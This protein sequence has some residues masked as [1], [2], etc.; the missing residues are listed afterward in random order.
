[1]NSR[2]DNVIKLIVGL[3][4]PGLEYAKTKHNA[5]FEVI[6]RLLQGLKFKFMEKTYHNAIIWN[7]RCKGQALTLVK[8]MSYMNKSGEPLA[9]LARKLQISPEDI[10]VV[11][12]DLDLPLGK[13]RIRKKGSDGGHNGIK[14]I[15]HHLDTENFPR[16]RIGIGRSEESQVDHVLSAYEGAER[17]KYDKVLDIASEAVK[18]ILY[19]GITNTMNDYNKKEI[20]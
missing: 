17:V 2:N 18:S 12:D 4:N 20:E 3:G 10:L 1:M 14:S 7:G 9:M 19:R 5:G 16:V 13:I 11:Y 8:P 6:D 15:I